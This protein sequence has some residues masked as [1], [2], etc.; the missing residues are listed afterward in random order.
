MSVRVQVCE[1]FDAPGLREA[2]EALSAADSTA[3]LFTGYEWCRCWHEHL[4][5][6]VQPLILLARD[7][8][9]RPLGLAPLG[10]RAGRVRWLGFLG[11]ERASGDHLGFV[12]PRGASVSPAPAGVSRIPETPT[13]AETGTAE[14]GTPAETGTA[15]ETGTGTVLQTVQAVPGRTSAS[16]DRV[17]AAI[18][19]TIRE[20]STRFDGLL[21]GELDPDG[22]TLAEV[23]TLAE[24]A[25]HPWLV[26]EQ[27]TC[28]YIDLPCDFE[29]FLGSLSGN[30]RHQVRRRLR[31]LEVLSG[32]TCE[33]VTDAAGVGPVLDAFFDLHHRRWMAQNLP[34]NYLDEAM[35]SWLRAFCA[36]AAQRGWLRAHVLSIGGAVQAVLIAFFHGG[37]ASYYQMGWAPDSPITSPG[38]ILLAHSIRQSIAERMSRYDFLRGDEAYKARWTSSAVQRITLLVGCRTPARAAIAADKVKAR[39]RG[40]VECCLGPAAW[41]RARRVLTGACS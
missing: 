39:V 12:L 11:R 40:L 30:M 19:K 41:Q 21:L 3:S 28:P 22:T 13:P 34:G 25:G 4:G 10:I 6:D 8:A 5:A 33:L 24:A 7:L 15:A 36:T 31:G 17:R 23:R 38:V 29:A 18:W 2:W 26:R 1:S 37:V 16:L 14:T 32:A 27:R 35:Q 9:G 20:Q